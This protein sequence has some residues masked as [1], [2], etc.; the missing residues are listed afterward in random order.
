VSENATI[1]VL[2]DAQLYDPNSLINNGTINNDG[3]I[4]VV[5][6]ITNSGTI[7]DI[8]SIYLIGTNQAIDIND[9]INTLVINGTGE[10]SIISNL[11]IQDY[12]DLQNGFLLPVDDN[13]I[14]LL[15][16]AST[17]V[18]STA[19]FVKGILY[20]RGEGS[21]Y[22]PIGLDTTFMPVEMQWIQ[23]DTL[24]L[25]GMSAHLFEKDSI[26]FAGKGAKDI[27]T[28]R[29]WK[30]EVVEGNITEGHIS[31]PILPQDINYYTA[32]SVVVVMSN[33]RLG[34]YRSLG[35]N[36]EVVSR[37]PDLYT[38]SVDTANYKFYTLG[39]FH[40][41][42]WDL[43]YIPNALSQNTP[44]INEQ[45]IRIYGSV[46]KDEEFS[47]V[48]TNKWGNVVFESNSVTEMEE[49][50]WDGT[51]IKTGN[52]EQI[53]I[54]HYYLKALTKRDNWYKKAGSIWIID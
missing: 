41:M 4:S 31:L 5:G 30:Q 8:G 9:T 52:R 47:F 1:S 51:N 46:F 18:G 43:L 40:E 20:S 22:Y 23:S 3:A 17:S 38:T 54:Y 13:K 28:T 37:I 36:D 7:N 10:K 21:K 26:P 39:I 14:V 25:V 19:S 16:N 12:I 53:G 29:Y 34:P 45:A 32:D 6:D 33:E 24:P 27:L 11:Y 44:D 42:N 35:P 49:N 2:K 48:V 15:Q 50:G